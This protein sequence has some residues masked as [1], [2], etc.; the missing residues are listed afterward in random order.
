M[1]ECVQTEEHKDEA[2]Q[3][4]CDEN[5]NLHEVSLKSGGVAAN[6]L[7][8]WFQQR[9]AID[10]AGHQPRYSTDG[11]GADVCDSDESEDGFQVGF[12]EVHCGRRALRRVDATAG[13]QEGG[14]LA[15]QETLGTVCAVAESSASAHYLVNP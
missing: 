10:G 13:H 12:Y 5:S 2:Q 14:L 4:A 11:D 9:T 7:K 3:D 1:E 8:C 15:R 6:L